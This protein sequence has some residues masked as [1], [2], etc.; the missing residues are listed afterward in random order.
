MTDPRRHGQHRHRPQPRPSS[1][2][3]SRPQ[4]ASRGASAAGSRS[5]RSRACAR[6]SH[7][8]D[9]LV[10]AVDGIDFHVDRG[11]IMGLVG[12]SGC[13]KS[14]TSLSI[15]RLV[16]RPG[17]IEAGEILFDGEDLLK[18][19]GRADAQHPRRPDLDDLP[20]AD[21]VAQ[22]G[23]GRRPPDRARFSR[24]TASMKGKAA[25]GPRARA[26][27]DGRHPRPGAP[28]QGVPARDVRRHGAARDD[29]HGARLRARAADRRRA[30]DGARRDDPG[31][32]P[33]PDA[34]AAATRPARRSSS[35]PTTWASSPRCATGSR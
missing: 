9:G 15:M 10:R 20:A 27:A 31:P 22:P 17:R 28:A 23:V 8:R 18:R 29:R 25:R 19:L 24:S 32:D 33:G 2:S 3:S 30:H 26:A 34:Q 4:P 11:E 35:S 21:L 16:A 6:R 5:S 12:E 13:G 14:V 1:R 7:T